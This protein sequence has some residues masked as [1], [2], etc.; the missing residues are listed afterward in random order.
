MF[1]SLLDLAV[2]ASQD[3]SASLIVQA[4]VAAEVVVNHNR[5]LIVQSRVHDQSHHVVWVVIRKMVA[6][7]LHEVHVLV[8]KVQLV[9]IVRF[10]IFNWFYTKAKFLFFRSSIAIPFAFNGKI[11]FTFNEPRFSF[12]IE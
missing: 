6:S 3:V 11:S 10:L 12:P 4:V 5:I 9:M 2:V 8:A 1:L 7:L